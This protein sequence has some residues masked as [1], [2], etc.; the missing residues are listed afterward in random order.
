[1]EAEVQNIK[2]KNDSLEHELLLVSK[3]LNTKC[4]QLKDCLLAKQNLG[5]K[6][7]ELNKSIENEKLKNEILRNEITNVQKLFNENRSQN[8][9]E[10]KSLNEE[11]KQINAEYAQKLAEI[12]EIKRQQAQYNEQNLL[13]LQNEFIDYF[14]K[15]TCDYKFQINTIENSLTETSSS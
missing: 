7:N 9:N 15:T 5:I 4:E 13:N 8:E 12:E 3:E 11:I 14:E 2:L 6:I 1:M 10:I